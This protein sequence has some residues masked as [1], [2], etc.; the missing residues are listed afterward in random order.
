MNR[1]RLL[2]AAMVLAAV[3]AVPAAAQMQTGSIL[4]RVTDDQGAAVPGVA[5]TLASP[6]LVAGTMSGVTDG[7][8]VNRFPSLQP[9]VYSVR[10]ELQ[11]F[12]TVIREN[13]A[14]QVGATVPLDLALQ[15]ATVAETVTVTGA[16]P[17]V[18]T[19]SAN[20]SVNL[21]EQLLQ[22]T[23]GGR[24]IWSLVE[25]KVPSLLITRPDVGGTSGRRTRA[26]L[27]ASTWATPQPSARPASTTTS[28]PS[29]TSRSRP[30]RTTSPCPRAACS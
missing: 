7:G 1:T 10:L 9:G 3:A 30:A 17:V 29:T 4:V 13:V 16:S 6:V 12:K 19:T 24:D 14:V 27:M 23:P 20:T 28:T 11:G 22:G 26:T 2:A 21:G 18:D 25:Y 15:L 8:G 5:V